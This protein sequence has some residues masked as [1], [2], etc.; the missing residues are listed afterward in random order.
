[1]LNNSSVDPTPATCTGCGA[2]RRVCPKSCITIEANKD[3]FGIA[4]INA[5]ECIDCG[6]CS[7]VC[8]FTSQNAYLFNPLETFA[9]R[10]NDM[11]ARF[12]SASGGAFAALARLFI[13]EGGYVCSAVDDVDC[14]GHFLLTNSVDDIS[15]M[16]G[17]KYYYIELD[18]GILDQMCNL[19]KKN[20]VLFCGLPCQVYAARCASKNSD[21]F[22]GVDLLCQGAPSYLVCK[23][24]RDEVSRR[25]SHQLI[26]HKF[27]TKGDSYKGYTSELEF[28]DGSIVR[29]HGDLNLY[30][31]SFQHKLFLRESCYNCPFSSLNRAGD[32]T[33][34]D[35]WGLDTFEGEPPREVSLLLCNS[36]SGKRFA[37]GLNKLG[38][39]ERHHLND[40]VN[41]NGPLRSPVKRP[42]MRAFSFPLMRRFGFRASTI[43]CY[44]K[45]LIKKIL[46]R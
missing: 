20:P 2:C 33:I 42:I 29:Q 9:F 21:N 32:I 7:K 18:D 4:H 38:A 25:A 30:N 8:P 12:K 1:M 43:M 40:A 26:G 15:L 23:K 27:R 46:F 37:A 6:A 31:C 45:Y 17:S 41:G 28:E 35:F 5:T 39:I 24:Y 13:E 22:I 16:Q 11:D 14:G 10:L 34:G 19:L 3:G 36:P 44:P